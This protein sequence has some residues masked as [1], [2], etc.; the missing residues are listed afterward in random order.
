MICTMLDCVRPMIHLWISGV[1][2]DV[3]VSGLPGLLWPISSLTVVMFSFFS[4]RVLRSAALMPLVGASCFPN[5]FSSIRSFPSEVYFQKFRHYP[6]WTVFLNWYKFVVSALS[7]LLNGMLYYQY[8]VT[9]LNI[10]IYNNAV[11]FCLQLPEMKFKLN[12]IEVKE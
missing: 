12:L 10:I 8:I 2:N 4:T 11:C 7:S 5:L 9:A 1:L 6:S 3:F